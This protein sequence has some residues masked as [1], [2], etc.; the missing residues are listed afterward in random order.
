M[1]AI[2]KKALKSAVRHKLIRVRLSKSQFNRRLKKLT[3]CAFAI[4]MF[5]GELAKKTQK[6][7]SLDSF[8]LPVCKNIRIKRCKIVKGEEHRGRCESKKEWYYGYKAHLI[9]AKDG[10]IIEIEFTPGAWSDQAAFDL[11]NFDLPEKARI[12]ADKAYNVYLKEDELNEAGYSFEPIRKKN[13]KKDD[14]KYVINRLRQIQRKHI[15]SNISVIQQAF[16]KTIHAVT[17]QGFLLKAVGFCIVF[18]LNF[19]L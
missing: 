7:F 11:L 8:P 3:D 19:Y 10:R 4:L 6:A 18:G 17:S 16:P 12:F 1:A 15:E 13:S 2:K 14:N 5:L 9:T